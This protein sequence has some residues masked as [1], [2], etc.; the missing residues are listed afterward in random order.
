MEFLE[1]SFFYFILLFF[2][3]A[4]PLAQSFEKRIFYYKKWE[5]LIPSILVMML[6]FIPWDIWFTHWSVWQFNYDYICGLKVFLLPIEEWLFF[7]IIPFACV[8][9]HEVL[10]YF[11]N[12]QLESDSY[13]KIAYLLA[14]LLLIFSVIYS[15][16]IYTLVCFTLT[17]LSFFILAFNKPKWMGSFFRTFFVSLVPFLVINGFLTGSFNEVPIVS[18]SSNEIIG[19]RILNIPIEDTMYCLLMLLIVISIYERKNNLKT[20]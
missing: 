16:R 13:I 7:I 5:R 10:N 15:D 4:Y 17:A 1:N 19:L 9:I 20:T 14:T 12:K 11:F 8:F 2:S 6:L 18:Y 3:L